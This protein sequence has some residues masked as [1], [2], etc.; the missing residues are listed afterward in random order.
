MVPAVPI[1]S[2]KLQKDIAKAYKKQQR[3]NADHML[4]V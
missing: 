1:P 3:A 2:N 4:Q